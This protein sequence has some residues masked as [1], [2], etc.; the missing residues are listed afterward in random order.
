ME[1]T[2][3][4]FLTG[5]AA[6]AAAVGAAA[7]VGRNTAHA[8]EAETE[9][10]GTITYDETIAWNGEYDVVVIGFGA[11][12]ASAAIAAADAGANVLI[13]EKAPLGEEGGNSRVCG[14][15]VINGRGDQEATKA[16]YEQLFGEF[17][18]PEEVLDVWSENVANIG[19]TMASLFELDSSEFVDCVEDSD[20]EIAV[21]FSSSSPEYPEFATNDSVRM[22]LLHDGYSDAYMWNHYRE[23]VVNRSDSIDV[24]LESPA[25]DLIQEPNTKTILGVKVS[26]G[27]EEL[28]IRAVNGVVLS[29]GGFENNTTMKRDYLGVANSSFYGTAYNTGDGQN[30]AKAAGADLWHMNAWESMPIMAGLGYPAEE[31]SNTTAVSKPT[32]SGAY[33]LVGTDGYR[34]VNEAESSRHGHVYNNGTWDIIRY[35]GKMYVIFD[36]TNSSYVD[37]V[38]AYIDVM[39]ASTITELAEILGT[40]E[41]VLE[42]TIEDFNFFADSG[43]DYAFHRDADTMQAFGDGPYYAAEYEA[44]VLNTQGGPRKNENAEVLDVDGNA[45]PHL[46]A[47]GECG[48]ICS[49]MYQ[50]GGNMAEALIFGQIA[51][52]NAATEKDP[53]DAYVVETVES[54]LVYTIGAAND[55]LTASVE[56]YEAACGENEYVGSST[57]MGGELIVKVTTEDGTTIE[58]LEVLVEYET[59]DI[60]G[61]ALETLVPEIIEAGTTDGIDTVS[62]ATVTSNALFEAIAEALEKAAE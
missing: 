25:I 48:G 21:L 49:N 22:T 32:E 3:R 17:E 18:V 12:G 13:V 15:F 16:Y 28:N 40:E 43:Y 4:N 42:Q 8:D 44:A 61:A 52:T 10:A 34:F 39:E 2:R 6:G 51:G 31:G 56:D 50:G 9:D 55:I 47:A 5:A 14:Q 62:G 35:P 41:G 27:G 23:Q 36:D 24:W 59:E 20:S 19:D 11:A 37:T 45:I 54:D 57:G 30:M 53:L 33:I 26:R 7:L 29:C 46:Y 38:S 60:G 58:D 1:L